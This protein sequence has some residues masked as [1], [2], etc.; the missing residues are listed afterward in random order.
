MFCHI[1]SLTC[2]ICLSDAQM[3]QFFRTN[4]KCTISLSLSV[5]SATYQIRWKVFLATS[6]CDKHVSH[7]KRCVRDIE[8][9]M[10]SITIL[11][12][13]PMGNQP[14]SANSLARALI[15]QGGQRIVQ[16][17]D[18]YIKYSCI[19]QYLWNNWW[20]NHDPYTKL[21]S[22]SWGLFSRTSLCKDLIKWI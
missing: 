21:I 5:N 3:L 15:A 12:D 6:G 22:W 9:Y 7:G 14:F 20:H 19:H 2:V 1:F 13:L 18:T 10:E 4:V 16:H 8:I 11:T 17:I